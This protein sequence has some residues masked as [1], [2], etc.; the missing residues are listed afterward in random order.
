MANRED[1]E[2]F[3]KGPDAWNQR[4]HEA[5]TYGA[6]LTGESLGY[7]L[8]ERYGEGNV[9][10][11][12]GIDLRMTDLRGASFVLPNLPLF[13]PGLD[14]K[15][16][17][18]LGAN[19]AGTV[20]YNADLT[21]A[22]FTE[23]DLRRAEFSGALLDNALFYK[24]DLTGANLTATRPWRSRLLEGS[25]SEP[26]ISLLAP[27]AESVSDVTAICQTLRSAHDGDPEGARFYYRGQSAAWRL[28]PSVM[29]SLALR[30]T[31][32]RMLREAMTRR[33]QDFAMATT[34]L[35]QW[36][37]AQHHGLP[38][39][40][41]D[42]TRNPLVAFYNA[43]REG[44]ETADAD[45]VVHVFVVP[46]S[47]VKTFDSDTISIVANFAKL[48]RWEQDL[49]LGKRRVDLPER[50]AYHGVTRHDYDLVMRRLLGL[51][52]QEKPRFEAAVDPRDLFKVFVVEPQ[53]SF[54]RIR[55]QSGA[56]FLSAYHERFERRSVLRWNQ[57]A[58][59]YRH[60]VTR[61]P[62]AAKRR[63]RDELTLLGVT[64][65]TMFPGLDEAARAITEEAP[66]R[67]GASSGSARRW[68]E[69]RHGV[70]VRR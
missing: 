30:A 12:A 70:S 64:R 60:Y 42:V 66:Q 9:P 46:R 62:A 11:Y 15:G 1:L 56:F 37:L 27:R 5:A 55:A 32:G 26:R 67:R 58:P 14:L 53:Q 31:E 28:R 40:L 45:G 2:L 68:H 4:A 23:S 50:R 38:T 35:A 29:R 61:V 18:F 7:R 16:A 10:S 43:A 49:L 25:N 63:L 6:D 51:I 13:R 17:W 3:L 34:A 24:A 59:V 39:R 33:P 52:G 22:I 36:V 44:G 69:P 20:F 8:V 47:L 41:L 48:S 21:D 57:R 19:A 54:E 65:E